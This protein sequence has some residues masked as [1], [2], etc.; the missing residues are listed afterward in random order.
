MNSEGT[1]I[2]KYNNMNLKLFVINY[3]LINK[4]SIYDKR[5]VLYKIKCKWNLVFNNN[6]SNDAKS[7]LIYRISVLRHNLEKH[8]K[9]NYYRRQELEFSLISEK[10]I[11]FIT[12]LDFMTYKHHMKQPMPM[13]ERRINR[14]LYRNKEPIETLDDIDLTVHMGTYK[15]GRD[16]ICDIM[17]EVE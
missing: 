5:F 7:K 14:N 16:N 8:K 13:L 15:N 6:I 4:V 9:I 2:N 1:V 10:N 11:T 3:I 17:N 12:S